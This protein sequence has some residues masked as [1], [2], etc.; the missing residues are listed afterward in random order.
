MSENRVVLEMKG[1]FQRLTLD[2]PVEFDKDNKILHIILFDRSSIEAV[3]KQVREVSKPFL[4]IPL[5][6]RL[7]G[8]ISGVFAGLMLL[9]GISTIAIFGNVLTEFLRGLKIEKDYDLIV[10]AATLV[11]G[12]LI[13]G[14]VP[15]LA[16][17]GDNNPIKS[18]FISWFNQSENAKKTF[19]K[20]LR[21]TI[22]RLKVEKV[23]VW[24]GAAPDFKNRDALIEAVFSADVS[25]DLHLHSD[26]R[27]KINEAWGEYTIVLASDDEIGAIDG[28]DTNQF[29][30]IRKLTS[31][32]GGEYRLPLL[33]LIH[34]SSL[35]RG[36]IWEDIETRAT[37]SGY[38]CST[39]LGRYLYELMETNSA[40]DFS[41]T[42]FDR[43]VGR[44]RNDYKILNYNT[45]TQCDTLAP[46]GVWKDAAEEYAEDI[47]SIHKESK[48]DLDDV[49]KEM[50]GKPSALY[51]ALLKTRLLDR[52][53]S[54]F[55][56]LMEEYIR[57]SIALGSYAGFVDLFAKEVFFKETGDL[58]P[59]KPTT[60]VQN[61]SALSGQSVGTLMQLAGAF[62]EIGLYDEAEQ[63]MDQLS[64]VSG[65]MAAVRYGRLLERRG[66]SREGIAVLKKVS[67][68]AD[69]LYLRLIESETDSKISCLTTSEALFLI[70]YLQQRT[71]IAYGDFLEEEKEEALACAEKSDKVLSLSLNLERDSTLLWRQGNYRACMSEWYDD[72]KV[73]YDAHMRT[74][75]LPGITFKWMLASYTNAAVCLRRH[76]VDVMDMASPSEDLKRFDA[77][78][79]LLD[80]AEQGKRALND[81]DELPV[82][83]HNRAMTHLYMLLSGRNDIDAER[84]QR[85]LTEAIRT[86]DRGMTIVRATSTTR[87]ANILSL[88]KFMLLSTKRDVYQ[89]GL[90]A[91]ETAEYDA[92]SRSLD[93]FRSHLN[94][95][96]TKQ[97]EAL[98]ALYQST[99][100]RT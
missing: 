79:D 60:E 77:V 50:D 100:A 91:E 59:P 32:M 37:T 71:W 94:S 89:I 82:V 96:E 85:L 99:L 67:N 83:L 3:T 26:E 33:Y 72:F 80:F 86:V 74:A 45:F 11:A 28:L 48:L 15:A 38:V 13:L 53:R 41:S 27:E 46:I 55:T 49:R 36:E 81:W 92:L 31:L 88:E 52:N 62:E 47:A 8:L 2:R 5:N 70:N 97:Y 30:L 56:R 65:P 21:R 23:V 63:L 39:E 75:Q 90:S 29:R 9:L 34:A 76:I 19:R 16:L 22:K 14:F 73:A 12:G 98:E 6:L 18:A 87:R 69:T 24:N 35:S 10:M 17:G 58:V 25:I 64:A 51:V 95:G 43:V 20:T 57:T 40:S 44:L 68:L 78:F 42:I 61:I 4:H 84:A 66:R 7:G 1:V 93:D 54:S